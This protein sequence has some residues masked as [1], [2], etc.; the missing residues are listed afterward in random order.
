MWIS[1]VLIVLVIVIGLIAGSRLSAPG[2][3]RRAVNAAFISLAVLAILF[4]ILINAFP[5]DWI[6]PFF[7]V[8]CIVVP[9]CLYVGFTRAAVS[10]QKAA[11]KKAFEIPRAAMEWT[12][13]DL[14][15]DSEPAK[16]A[17]ATAPAPAVEAKP[18]AKAEAKPE[19]KPKQAEAKKAT[20]AQAV[21]EPKKVEAK[22]DTKPEAKPEAKA[23]KPVQAPAKKAEAAEEKSMPKAVEA[24]PKPEVKESQPEPKL[25]PKPKAEPKISE[26]I[27]ASLTAKGAEPEPVKEPAP[28]FTAAA[29]ADL[30]TGKSEQTEEPAARKSLLNE[31]EAL[32]ERDLNIGRKIAEGAS[33]E[34]VRAAEAKPLEYEGSHLPASLQIPEKPAEPAAPAQPEPAAV[35]ASPAPAAAPSTPA[36]TPVAVPAPA[37]EPEPKKEPLDPFTEFCNKAA[38]LR[39][40]GSYAVAAVIFNKAA[41]SAPSA[42]DAR[43]AQFDEL[44]CYVKAG[45]TAKAKALAAKLRQSSVLTRFERIKLDAVERMG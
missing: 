22:P 39:D 10:A 24:A 36:P 9:I 12:D 5:G 17:T 32:V 27:Q 44:S 7:T 21:A 42:G 1:V 19:S 37:P 31:I 20:P 41:A 38:T 8:A 30:L 40:Q 4:F 35:P 43:T 45:E 6:V 13:E 11:D 33:D 2:P 29:S 3:Q 15:P 16:A 28:H 26:D 18:K 25:E 14:Q 34:E 23:E